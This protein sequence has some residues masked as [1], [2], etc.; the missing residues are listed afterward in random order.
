MVF[1]VTLD[2]TRYPVLR[3]CGA[4]YGSCGTTTP[5]QRAEGT[6]VHFV[7]DNEPSADYGYLVD[8]NFG[9]PGARP[10][11]S[12]SKEELWTKHPQ[13]LSWRTVLFG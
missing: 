5:T 6:A 3:T 12:L 11:L 9:G 13:Q 4:D 7:D 10:A 8:S 2:T 1:H